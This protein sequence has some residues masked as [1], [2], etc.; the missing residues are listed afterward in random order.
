MSPAEA[1]RIVRGYVAD[2]ARKEAGSLHDF[3]A[4]T[5]PDALHDICREEF[6][7]IADRLSKRPTP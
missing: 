4:E 2:L 3:M 6:R 1:R 7:R 5:V